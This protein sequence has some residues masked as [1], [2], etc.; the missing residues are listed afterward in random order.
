MTGFQVSFPAVG[1]TASGVLPALGLRLNSHCGLRCVRG[2]RTVGQTLRHSGRRCS[3][4]SE[5]ADG[6]GRHRATRDG[7]DEAMKQ[8]WLP[9]F[10]YPDVDA[11]ESVID[12]A[13]VAEEER[14]A[15]G[16]EVLPGQ[17]GLFTA[18]RELVGL[19]EA[20]L[21]SGRF[22]DAR[23]H[24]DALLDFEGPSARTRDLG[25]LDV[26]GDA[27]FWDRPLPMVLTQW[28]TLHRDLDALPHLRRLIC[29]GGLSRLLDGHTPT[30]LVQAT[31]A[32][33]A[34]LTN[35]L[36]AAAGPDERLPPEAAALLRDALLDGSEPVPGDFD[37]DRIVDLLAENHGPA[38][39]ACLGALRQLW[40]VP[41]SDASDS[42]T[43]VVDSQDDDERGREFWACLRRTVSCGRDDPAAGAARKR[44]KQLDAYMHALFM[45][46]GVRRE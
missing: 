22:E 5:P 39:L 18:E 16:A 28:L 13:G 45:R 6:R 33:L 41:R 26:V 29:D 25:T 36:C 34:P 19:M 1:L 23:R 32:M 46:D 31:P 21:A 37:D 12:T 17:R 3:P 44:M 4:W 27:G 15:T 24:R 35:R 8:R 7:D 38:W 42:V 20:A 11:P 10:D 14:G 43:F 30:E 40:P 2:R 9:E